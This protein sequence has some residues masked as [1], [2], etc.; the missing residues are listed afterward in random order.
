[1]IGERDGA[2]AGRLHDALDGRLE[3]YLR[4]THASFNRANDINT[5]KVIKGKTIDAPSMTVVD[6]IT[7]EERQLRIPP[8]ELPD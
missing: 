4:C 6:V 5:Q 8:P 7:V 3:G 1:M 2:L